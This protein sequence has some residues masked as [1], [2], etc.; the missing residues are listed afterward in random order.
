MPVLKDLI[1]WSEEEFLPVMAKETGARNCW[2]PEITYDAQSK[3]Y[4]IYWS[5]TITGMFAK[6]ASTTDNAYNHRLYY[7]TTKDFRTYTPTK[8]LYDPGFNVIDATIVPD[9][10]RFVLFMKDETREPA[11]K[12][13]KIAFGNS[14]T[15][16]YTKASAPITGK[17]WAEGP[18][19]LKIGQ[20]LG[21][22]F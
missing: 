11:Q 3:T 21:G 14:L 2:A 12:N 10:N 6:T 8:L 5:T 20:P 7:I 4:M 19:T 22:L 1:H 15:G 13:L 18:T 9:G 16:P 17:Y